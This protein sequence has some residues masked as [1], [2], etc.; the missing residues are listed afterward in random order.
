MWICRLRLL[1]NKNSIVILWLVQHRRQRTIADADGPKMHDNDKG[2]LFSC[3]CPN[4][5]ENNDARQM[6][7]IDQ[8]TRHK[9]TN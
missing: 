4:S 8:E 7:M 9:C 1:H 2:V 5:C 6:R 3:L